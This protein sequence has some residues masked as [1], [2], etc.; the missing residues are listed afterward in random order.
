M[1]FESRN[2]KPLALS[3]VFLVYLG[4]A[5][6]SI[7]WEF[8]SYGN[9]FHSWSQ[10]A[11]LSA[12]MLLGGFV[13]IALYVGLSALMNRFFAW[14]KALE[15]IFAQLLTPISYFQILVISLLSGFV[16]EWFFRGVLMSHFGLLVSSLAFGLCHFV[17]ERRLWIWGPWAFFAGIVFGK[18]YEISGSLVLCALIHAGI[19]AALLILLN[20]KVLKEPQMSGFSS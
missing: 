15:K 13:L 5:L 18:I 3:L 7:V 10:S 6:I 14:A 2:S 9:G 19:N 20:M 4:I 16:E 1:L 8:L 12:G 17:P 11:P